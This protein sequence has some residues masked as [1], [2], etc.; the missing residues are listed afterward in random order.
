VDKRGSGGGEIKRRR[1]S[2]QADQVSA[3]A[4]SE[5]VCE[6]KTSRE[7]PLGPS[8]AKRV[9]ASRFREEFSN[10][11]RGKYR[12]FFKMLT[13]FA[14]LAVG[15]TQSIPTMPKSFPKG[16]DPLRD[17]ILVGETAYLMGRPV[18]LGDDISDFD[19]I[20]ANR[21]IF[22][23]HTIE[24]TPENGPRPIESSLWLYT[25]GKEPVRLLQFKDERALFLGKLLRGDVYV[26]LFGM[27]DE[28]RTERDTSVSA[29]QTLMRIDLKSRRT[30]TISLRRG[31]MYTV[32]GENGAEF[33]VVQS[34]EENQGYG[35][36]EAGV[37]RTRDNGATPELTNFVVRPTGPATGIP[38]RFQPEGGLLVN[39]EKGIALD[40][41]TMKALPVPP[42]Q[43][44]AEGP[45]PS[46]QLTRAVEKSGINK[47]VVIRNEL[48]M[49][50]ASSDDPNRAAVTFDGTWRHWLGENGIAF[51]ERGLLKV[52][53]IIRMP[54]KPFLEAAAAAESRD[55]L[56]IAKQMG[57]A[58]AIYL[59]DNDDK[60]P[61]S[62][63][64]TERMR[65]YVKNERMLQMYR[66]L[67]NDRI[68]VRTADVN[69]VETGVVQGRFGRAVG[70]LDT[71]ARWFPNP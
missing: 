51:D 34:Y 37:V 8:R 24:T 10:E 35:A 49:V 29:T 57:T 26:L 71:S 52:R 36:A 19:W 6:A 63:D 18:T 64:F 5:V 42:R 23:T 28:I 16:I 13:A 12:P 40:V 30:D 66:Y 70:Y 33:A 65:P 50:A 60:L 2:A 31:T 27:P 39:R 46:I 53:P 32:G 45:L 17:A 54:R 4:A 59:S 15:L 25:I 44:P 22:S 67:L 7:W 38:P 48:W 47:T 68:D 41:K 11:L 58:I 9:V 20:D 62:G 69:N 21:A 61:P 14:L 43:K 1:T 56:S 55:R 3:A